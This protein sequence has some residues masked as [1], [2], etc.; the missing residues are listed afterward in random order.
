MIKIIL[1]LVSYMPLYIVLFCNNLLNYYNDTSKKMNN[2]SRILN[3][4][5]TFEQKD[6][7]V[8]YLII[9]LITVPIVLFFIFLFYKVR[10]GKSSTVYPEN[11]KKT[12]DTIINYLI[13]YII[14]FFSMDITSPSIYF[15]GNIIL[16]FVVMVLFIRLD[17]VYL[18]PPL[19]LLGFYIFTDEDEN[20]YYLTRNSFTKLKMA[21]KAKDYLKIIRITSNFYYIK[22]YEI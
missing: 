10:T 20:K 11:Y 9:G 3:S 14:P 22:K 1:F 15:W 6:T 18:N 19:I 13:T 2:Q 12:G 21:K 5:S 7:F 16:I 4:I 8:F 17:A